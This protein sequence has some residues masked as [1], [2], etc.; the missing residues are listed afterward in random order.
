VVTS[1]REIDFSGLKHSID[2]V[3]AVC[4]GG[5]D[6]LPREYY[7]LRGDSIVL[8]ERHEAPSYD[9][10]RQKDSGSAMARQKLIESNHFILL[11]FLTEGGSPHWRG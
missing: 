10:Y 3:H 6:D 11:A 8:A 9:A 1:L 7:V 5:H 2:L 4:N